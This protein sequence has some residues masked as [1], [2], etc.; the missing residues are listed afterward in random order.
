MKLFL[1][2]FVLFPLL[3]I[4]TSV[5]SQSSK[6]S[7]AKEPAWITKN[8][9]DYNKNA[10]DKNAEDGYI[11]IAF[12]KQYNLSDQ[13][14]YIFES[15]KI[16]SQSGVQNA[17]EVYASF[18]PSYQQLIFH[19]LRVIR[20]GTTV[21]QLKISNIKTVHQEKELRNFIYNGRIDAV[22]IL[23]D[24]RKGDVI[25]YSYTLK[26]ANPIFKN[27][28]TAALGLNFTTPIY[29]IYYKL[30]VPQGRKLNFKNLNH[31][32]EP[33]T[34]SVN[35]QQVFEWKKMDVPPLVMQDYT[36]VWFN[37]YAEVLISEF[38]SWK[39]VNDWALELFPSKK[40]L[41]AALQAKIKE[42]ENTNSGDEQKV[43]AA[44]KFVQDDIRYM[45]I[46]MGI[47]SHKPADPS[48]VFAQ[49]F[50]DCKE[51]SYL[52]SCMLAAMNIEAR[53]V[54]INTTDQHTLHDMLPA[55]V[56]FDHVTVR[57]KLNNNYYWF[58]PT[59][60]YQRGDIKNLFYP[61]YQA[62]LVITDS[63]T[64][65]TTISFRSVSQQH[66]N[67]YFR[68][69][70]MSGGGTLIVT[71][72]FQ[73]NDAD[74]VRR[75]FNNSSIKELMNSYQKFYA[76]YYEDIKADSLTYK[77]D[78]STG[79]FSTKEYYS[80]PDF[81]KKGNGTL[82]RFSFSA[83]TI[84]S[85]LKRVKEKEREMPIGLNFPA[86]YKEDITIELPQEW[87]VTESE[88][89]KKNECYTYN[90]KFYCNSNVVHLSADY[91]NLKDH[92]SIDEASSYFKDLNANEDFAS[93][94]ISSGDELV[95]DASKPVNK[96]NSNLISLLVIGAIAG[97]VVW[98]GKRK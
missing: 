24:I 51:K 89:H 71:S 87:S 35:G 7:I 61:D 29:E 40:I 55:P 37:P 91:E 64:A 10:L 20:N 9:M 74:D 78:D 23:E 72:T 26:G 38:N 54:L 48:K 97:G 32:N 83:F 8:I 41:S 79:I 44:L 36:P 69:T 11:D 84:G 16:I 6:I 53:P 34:S 17:S 96:T 63:T 52:L 58:D 56:N 93:F 2:L 75:Q 31:A 15:K 4:S 82:K 46:E 3:F 76:S 1:S 42:I 43:Q 60:A 80:I 62:G 14:L 28:F 22:L 68:V 67:E 92:A 86:K 47:N 85:N 12:E 50:G 45:G 25:E 81:W 65:L 30:I 33:V 5:L 66:V 13:S 95:K 77:D 18:D 21:N 59:I 73:G 90:Y 27:K 39:E 57:I 88:K 19:T 98:W 94:E 70:S 49:R